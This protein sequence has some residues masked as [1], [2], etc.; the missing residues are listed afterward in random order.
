MTIQEAYDSIKTLR[1]LTNWER[2]DLDSTVAL[3]PVD[4][5]GLEGMVEWV[6]VEIIP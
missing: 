5:Y 6:A 3:E 1:L 2:V 4:I